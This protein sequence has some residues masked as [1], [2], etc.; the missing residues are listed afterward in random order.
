MKYST[1]VL[2][3]VLA[4]CSTL[5]PPAFTVPV[6]SSA[7][8]QNLVVDLFGVTFDH[9]ITVSNA[10]P[11]DVYLN[12]ASYIL[13]IG[14][15]EVTRGELSSNEV[16]TAR[17]VS[18]ISVPISLQFE[19]LLQRF[20]RFSDRESLPYTLHID[21]E[22]SPSAMA[23]TE[24][25]RGRQSFDGTIPVLEQPRVVVDTLMLKSF[26]LA[27]AELELRVRIV[28]PNAVPLTV[29]GT[30]LTLMVD[31]QAWHRQEISQ[32]FTVPVRSDVVFDAPFRMRPRDYGTDVY[33]KLNMSQ[34]FEF[35]VSGTARVAAEIP[36]FAG[37]QGWTF[38]SRSNQQFERLSN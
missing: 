26:T 20:G 9:P 13:S 5:K 8:P 29:S 21:L 28:N 12:Q 24:T 31:E 27:M 14:G 16:M 36:G 6:V 37:P 33:R 7:E 22:A 19:D 32:T 11:S 30:S 23:T 1:A 4:S 2:L 17:S 3:L 38:S 18:E 35:T 10:L 25:L 15:Q 34:A